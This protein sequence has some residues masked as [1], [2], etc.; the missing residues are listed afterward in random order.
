M[1]SKLKPEI[2][3]VIYNDLPDKKYIEQIIELDKQLQEE[4]RNHPLAQ[5]DIRRMDD[6]E[7][8]FMVYLKRKDWK[9]A[10]RVMGVPRTIQK[11]NF[12]RYK[13]A[14]CYAIIKAIEGALF[15]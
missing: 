13:G 8:L 3:D 15:I 6:M 10:V 14:N 4:L 5:Q 9:N 1:C 2:K 7:M 12:S 11:D